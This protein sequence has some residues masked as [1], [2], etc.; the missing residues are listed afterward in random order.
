VEV[1]DVL[2]RGRDGL[3]EIVLLDAGGH[4]GESGRKPELSHPLPSHSFRPRAPTRLVF[5]LPL[6]AGAQA[7]SASQASASA[8]SMNTFMF[9]P[10]W[11]AV[12]SLARVMRSAAPP[13]RA[14]GSASAA[15]RL[16]AHRVVLGESGERPYAA[17]VEQHALFRPGRAG[18]PHCLQEGDELAQRRL[19][20]GAD[21]DVVVAVSTW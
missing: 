17:Q 3:D 8:S 18:D 5:D 15:A 11:R 13:K 2:Q 19:P 20:D 21:D 1:A 14:G 9:T 7:A 6:Q 4:G 16:P 12:F 10:A